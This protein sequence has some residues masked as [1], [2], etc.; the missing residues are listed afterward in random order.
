MAVPEPSTPTEAI[1]AQVWCDLLDVDA[2]DVTDDFFAVGGHSM[3]AVQVVHQ[4]GERTGVELEL[5]DF[6]DLG[7]VEDVA[8][9]LD[10]LSANRQESVLEGEL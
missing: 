2:V 10:R 3:V 6:F 5:A 1:V 7:T 8:A 9:E 4:L